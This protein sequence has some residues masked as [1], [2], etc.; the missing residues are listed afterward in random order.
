MC[1]TPPT[2]RDPEEPLHLKIVE[3]V[4]KENHTDND[5]ELSATKNICTKFWDIAG[6]VY[7][8]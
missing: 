3:N 2:K 5:N 6:F 1:P 7:V 8:T 4:E